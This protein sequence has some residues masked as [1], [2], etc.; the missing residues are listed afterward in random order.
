MASHCSALRKATSAFA[1]RSPS[2]APATAK[3]IQPAPPKTATPATTGPGGLML[4]CMYFLGPFYFHPFKAALQVAWGSPYDRAY[5]HFRSN[6]KLPVN[7]AA[8]VLGLVHILFGNFSLMHA[9]DTAL[10]SQ[11]AYLSAWTAASWGGL[12]LATSAPVGVRLLAV[13]GVGVAFHLRAAWLP[14]WVGLA[15]LEAPLHV[16]F[17]RFGDG[18]A[19]PTFGSLALVFLGRMGVQAVLAS[20]A[21]LLAPALEPWLVP[22]NCAALAVLA[23]GSVDPFKKPLASCYWAG[24][25]GWAFALATRQPAAYFYGAGY[26]ASLCQVRG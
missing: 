3:Q 12:L 19:I 26:V 13:G 18:K 17:L 6:H 25:L 1:D 14:L 2:P 24:A 4:F 21:P 10:P 5:H 15:L 22:L 11:F 7:I 16:L 20:L 9:V 8:H 23:Y